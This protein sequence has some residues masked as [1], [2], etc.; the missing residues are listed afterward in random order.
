MG[1]SVAGPPVQVAHD[2]PPNQGC[3][4]LEHVDS[5]DYGKSSLNTVWDG[6]A[7]GEQ[8]DT[9]CKVAIQVMART[10]MHTARAHHE[11]AA[12]R[13]GFVVCAQMS[14]AGAGPE[15]VVMKP[16]DN[17]LRFT[18]STITH[19]A[20][21]VNLPARTEAWPVLPGAQDI[22][23]VRWAWSAQT[24]KLPKAVLKAT[25]RKEHIA[26]AK[27]LTNGFAVGLTNAQMDL[28]I[29]R[30]VWPLN[31]NRLPVRVHA[32]PPARLTCALMRSHDSHTPPL[33]PTRVPRDRARNTFA[34]TRDSTTSRRIC[35]SRGPSR[36]AGAPRRRSSPHTPTMRRQAPS[37][38]SSPP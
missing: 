22:V 11:R 27:G 7:E 6:P 38:R 21:K 3:S 13:R 2:W 23:G 4:S 8:G 30:G 34:S 25:K 16:R 32:L 35:P 19:K 31:A 1:P 17:H 14:L 28:T 10:M 12:N 5:A 29:L 20:R 36:R 9:W 33:Y 18:G 24:A 26:K 37:G 15:A